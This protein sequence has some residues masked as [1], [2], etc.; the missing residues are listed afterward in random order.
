MIYIHGIGHFH[1]ENIIDNQFLETLDIGTNQNWIIE[2]VGIK[3]RRTV[4]SLDYIRQT[5]NQHPQS[6]GSHIQFTNAKTA[7][8]AAKMALERAHLLAEDIGMV[9]AGSC[10]PQYSLPSDAC[11]IA[12]ELGIQAP[13][14]DINSACSTFAAQ[15][16]M[17]NSMQADALPDYILLVIPDNTTRAVDYRDRRSAVL[18]GDATCAIIVSKKHTACA[19]IDH[20]SLSSN[21]QNWNKVLLPTGGHFSQEGSTVQ[22]FAIKTTLAS[23]QTLRDATEVTFDQHYF[24]GHQANLT[25]LESVC[26]I[27]NISEN[28]HLYNV[29]YFGNCG[30][31]GAPCVLSQNWSKFVPGDMV[32]IIVVGAGL[33]WGGMVL[34]FGDSN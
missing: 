34:R 25:M 5:F 31:A 15:I 17:I 30:A 16:H 6:I 20:T 4:L 19:S 27:G 14:F 22:K 33:S 7:A 8:K 18:W 29:D 21:P 13:A 28:R 1:P 11:V 9:I 10:S 32:F 24:I 2:R 12:G 26:R 23:L 3:E